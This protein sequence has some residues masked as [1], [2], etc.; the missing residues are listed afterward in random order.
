MK[1]FMCMCCLQTQ[2]MDVITTNR[3]YSWYYDPGHTDTIAT[4]LATD[5][6]DWFRTHGKPMMLT[7]YGAGTVAG[8]HRVSCF[9]LSSS[10]SP[11]GLAN[12]AS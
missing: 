6:E 3:Y 2:F 5:L 4:R 1:N 8:I 7:E 12:K 9:D 11:S 10:L